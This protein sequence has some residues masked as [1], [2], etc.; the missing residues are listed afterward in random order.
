M[1]SATREAVGALQRSVDGMQPIGLADAEQVLQA[2]RAIERNA[3][4]LAALVDPNGSGDAKVALVG[5]VFAGLERAPR[6]VLEVAVRQRWSSSRDL[7]AGLE[8]AGIRMAARAATDVDVAAELH[9][10]A[11]IVASD[12]DLELALGGVRG[13]Q[14]DKARLVQRLLAPRASAATV[15]IVEH[16]VRSPR[17]RR[18]GALLASAAD[19]VARADESTL[20]T[21][22][23]AERL[24][25]AHVARL[26][27]G[28]AKR[29]GRRVQVQQVVDPQ[30]IG[31]LRVAIAD[32][33]IDGT[34]RQKFNDLRLQL[35]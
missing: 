29:Y 4:I 15:L 1:R 31:G 7:L 35:G 10:V 5:R 19:S 34:I 25:D 11:S 12:A 28:L 16:L 26:E 6:A 17:G 32:D 22:T 2:A 18:I 9:D 33:V 14:E 20:A 27:A 8:V 3:Q 24:D 13:D 30:V 21:V 23:T